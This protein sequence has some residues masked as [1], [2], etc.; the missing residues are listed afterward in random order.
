MKL[1]LLVIAVH[2]DDAELGS[3]GTILS[4]VAQGK[5]VG[6]V[7]LT[8]GE[9]GTRGTPEIRLQEAA[10]AAH[11]LGLSARENMNF[12]D[13]FFRNDE[14][15][16]RAL[17]AAIRKYQPEIVIANAITDRHPDHGR[18]SALIVDACF[19]SGLRQIKTVDNVGADAKGEAQE[20]WRPKVVYHLIQDRYIK[21]DFIVDITDFYEKKQESL[22]AYKSQFYDPNSTEPMSYIAS[23]E[24]ME[25]L[26]AR[27]E[28]FGHVIGVKYGEGFTVDRTIGVKN[29]FDLI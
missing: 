17:I 14:E 4:L 22:L 1:D 19:Y 24:F 21:P 26:R 3:A 20:A 7:D 28:E 18:A 5:K 13:G 9:L 2:P 29:I 11:I 25:F 6:I 27:A 15:H 16:Q 8:R 23:K 12:R 10:A